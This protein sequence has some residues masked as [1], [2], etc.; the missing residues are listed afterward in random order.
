MYCITKIYTEVGVRGYLKLR[1]QLQK[2]EENIWDNCCLLENTEGEKNIIK[3]IL[4]SDPMQA[5]IITEALCG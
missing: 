3:N 1:F 2:W 4:L 5:W